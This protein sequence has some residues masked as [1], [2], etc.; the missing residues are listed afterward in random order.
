M[1]INPGI[2]QGGAYT[3]QQSINLSHRN[4]CGISTA[5]ITPLG[6][7]QFSFYSM[8]NTLDEMLSVEAV[9]QAFITMQQTGKAYVESPTTTTQVAFLES[10]QNYALTLYTVL[11]TNP[12]EGYLYRLSV[13]D[14]SGATI[15]ESSSPSTLIVTGGALTTV[16]LLTNPYGQTTTDLYGIFQAPCLFGYLNPSALQIINSPY[17]FN[18][19][20]FPESILSIATVVVG[21]SSQKSFANSGYG[22]AARQSSPRSGIGLGYYVSFYQTI[23]SETGNVVDVIFARIGLVQRVN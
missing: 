9:K 19:T 11:P 2:V 20:A 23:F 4:A 6:T 15:W 21:V 5:T 14:A 7:G 17:L 12:P 3:I 13:Y 10:I 18:Q 16:P 22:Y 1:R 8:K